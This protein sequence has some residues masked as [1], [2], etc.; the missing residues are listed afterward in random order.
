MRQI[1]CA[2]SKD[3][4]VPS[5]FGR[6]NVMEIGKVRGLVCVIW[7]EEVKSKLEVGVGCQEKLYLSPSRAPWTS[8]FLHRQHDDNSSTLKYGQL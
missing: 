1:I 2:S 8:I 4:S 3:M 6:E 7:K 5:V